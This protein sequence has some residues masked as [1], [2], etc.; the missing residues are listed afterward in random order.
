ML[1]TVEF[2]RSWNGLFLA[3]SRYLPF[4]TDEQVPGS[5]SDTSQA[6][7]AGSLTVSVLADRVRHLEYREIHCNDDE[8]DHNAQ[9]DH[10]DRFKQ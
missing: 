1:H 3:G 10:H 7:L 2:A 8:S 6:F 4:L 9:H 5:N